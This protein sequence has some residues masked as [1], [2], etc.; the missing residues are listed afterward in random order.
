MIREM[1]AKGYKISNLVELTGMSDNCIRSIV[2]YKSWT[3]LPSSFLFSFLICLSKYFRVMD[4]D[5]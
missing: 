3:H 5:L 2:N 1:R 4:S